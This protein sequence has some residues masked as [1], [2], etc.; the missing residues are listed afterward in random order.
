M[1]KLVAKTHEEVLRNY[2]MQ[3]GCF[4]RTGILMTLDGSD[5]DKI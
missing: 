4:E 5:D 2:K 1:S 3:I